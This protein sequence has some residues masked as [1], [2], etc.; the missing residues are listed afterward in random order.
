MDASRSSRASLRKIRVG[1][2]ADVLSNP[3]V[4]GL[5]RYT[6]ELLRALSHRDDIEIF[7]FSQQELNPQHLESIR[8]TSVVF[9]A[10]RETLWVDLALPKKLREWNIDVFHAPAERGIPLLKPCPLVVTVHESYERT[11]WRELYPKLKSRLWYWKYELSNY[12]RADALI[13]VSD[14]TR[15]K[16]IE[17]NVTRERQCHRIYLA[18]AREF[19][20]EPARNDA[21]VIR[22]CG[23]S[24]PYILY[25][26][27]YD[28][29]KNVR[30]LVQ[31]FDAAHL[32]HHRLV[33]VAR[34]EWEYPI[35][36][37]HWKQ[38]SCLPKLCLLELQPREIPALYRHADFF[39]NPSSW[40]SFS[41]QLTEAMA[42]GTPL[43]CSNST[44]M[45]EIALD[46]AQYF[47][48][49]NQEELVS[50]LQR[51]AAD[52]QLKAQLRDKGFER[53]KA[54]SWDA[55]AEQTVAIYRGLLGK[56]FQQEPRH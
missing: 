33:I 53:V 51:F 18:P 6:T 9:P 49:E 27:G 12:F 2:N 54:F 11:Y 19:R 7:L 45:P 31:A 15:R 35:L 22:K 40:E 30:A 21:E 26:G 20:P 10:L 34:K 55:T 44:A 52:S 46:A 24:V 41:F 50:W 39:V 13:T 4:R 16:L 3:D 47:D 42:C 36:L 38:L 32:P 25:V 28:K 37:E 5:V 14:T 56:Q 48:P 8:A 1:F 23:L 29:R 43:L 17:L